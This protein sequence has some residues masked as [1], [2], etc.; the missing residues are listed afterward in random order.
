MEKGMKKKIR[1]FENSHRGV[2]KRFVSQ[3]N[4]YMVRER[5]LKGSSAYTFTI[6]QHSHKESAKSLG[7]VRIC[8]E[9]VCI[10]TC[11][12]LSVNLN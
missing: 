8:K 3:R 1:A 2:M 6:S 9:R 4:K 7:Y 11:L 10:S 12:I 5:L